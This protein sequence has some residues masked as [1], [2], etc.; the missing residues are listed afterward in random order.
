MTKQ[1]VLEQ[2]EIFL[3]TVEEM[4]NEDGMSENS[5][6]NEEAYA[7]DEAEYLGQEI[8]RLQSFLV[9]Q[10]I[11]LSKHDK[12]SGIQLGIQLLSVCKK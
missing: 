10:V 4:A 11:S 1:E 9:E 8:P 7:A 6:T 3:D 2:L 12:A 5:Q